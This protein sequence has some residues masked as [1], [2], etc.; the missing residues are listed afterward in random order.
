MRTT[1][2]ALLTAAATAAA[3]LVAT[4]AAAVSGT[5]ATPHPHPAQPS[6]GAVRS[7]PHKGHYE[8][9]RFR[10]Q[11]NA[12]PPSLDTELHRRLGI[13]AAAFLAEGQA[14]SDA[15]Q[16]VSELRARGV[17]VTGARM[18]GTGLT[19][20]V[21]D[22][23]DTA[24]V[25][26]AGATAT[27]APPEKTET[28][29]APAMSS[30]AD[31]SSPLQGGDLWFY[32]NDPSGSGAECSLGFT[33]YDAAHG[34]REFLTAGHCADYAHT[35]DPSPTNGTVFAVADG[36][37]ASYDNGLNG[38]GVIGTLDQASFE[39]SGGS[40]A[41]L[42]DVTSSVVKPTPT[43]GTWGSA[44]SQASTATGSSQ[45]A[46]SSGSSIPVHGKTAA[47]AGAPICHSGARTG[48]QCG[49]VT[50]AAVQVQVS[51][52]GSVQEV[53]SVK[54]SACILPGDSGGSFISGN[55]AV[56][57]ASAGDFTPAAPS[58][59]DAHRCG[60]GTSSYAYPLVATQS[61]ESS[62]AQTL[63]SF[64]LAVATPS[65][66]PVATVDRSGVVTALSGTLSF[67]DGTP[68]ASGTPVS[69]SIDNST[70][71]ATASAADSNGNQAWR[72]AVSG[73]SAG[74]HS[75]TLTIGTGYSATSQNGS[76]TEAAAAPAPA[77]TASPT[78]QPTTPAPTAPAPT[79][80]A[81]A[82][83][84]TPTTTR[85]AG[86]DRYAT[87]VAASQKQFPNGA[88][89]VML[90]SGANYPDALAAAP[91]AAAA[92]GDLL[93]TAPTALPS[94]VQAELRRLKPSAVYLIGGT[95]AVGST[96]A[97]QV[98]SI[99]GVTAGR[100]AGADRYA[101]S[102]AI[103]AAF[104]PTASAAFIATGAGFPDALSA[105]GAAAGLKAPVMLVPGTGS[106]PTA[107][108]SAQLTRLHPTNVYVVGG[109]SVVSAAMQ[110]TLAASRP[111]IR[112]AGADRY[113]TGVAVSTKFHPSARAAVIAS[114]ANFP[115]ALVG[116]VLAGWAAGPL[117][118]SAPNC[119]PSSVVGE[120]SRL[121]ATDLILMGG[122]SGLS[123]DV[124]RK[125]RC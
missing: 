116:S 57:V 71:V 12:L 41:G 18:H 70:T 77:P 106:A 46:Q 8:L 5:R 97:A 3:L 80:A 54:T 78:P 31:G 95:A 33:G 29:A 67:A 14:A 86:T 120:L 40:D 84:A 32:Q 96:V 62:V 22:P 60:S 85:I 10:K 44:L 53:D 27:V 51:T 99:A 42:V 56:G 79:S 52:R 50:S 75:Y 20:T 102:A 48:W 63:P 34:S 45:G 98:R 117:L 23:S 69:L 21:A 113:A 83:S 92:G 111:V 90:A 47:I 13:S 124:A 36:T 89:T 73:L 39:F 26:A 16:L 15:A 17:R 74:V 125:R 105:A 65:T 6:V 101:T 82:A 24:A 115:D 68:A 76:L 37:P 4:P 59:A 87:A 35:G 118:L 25:R 114:G 109:T 58:G 123:D 121:G 122:T 64:Q 110:R 43:V 112:L 38:L 7:R 55:Y 93:L 94:A 30:P 91:A 88:R 9:G 108:V 100:L 28:V 2:F 66:T 103:A 49:T 81:A 104:F 61:G 72:F 107:A 1:A 19:V 11:A 119:M